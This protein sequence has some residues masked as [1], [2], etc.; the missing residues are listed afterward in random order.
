MRIGLVVP[1][2]IHPSGTTDVIPALI[3]LI[4]RLARRH[5]VTAIVLG[6]SFLPK[7]FVLHG[8]EVIDL[9]RARMLAPD[10]P[11]A[12]ASLI[13]ILAPRKVELIHAFWAG[14]PGFAAG[15]AA[16][17]LRTPMLLSIAGGEL[18]R[19][20]DIRYG[21]QRSPLER[22]LVR[23][24]LSLADLTTAG[25]RALI[26]HLPSSFGARWLPLGADRALFDHLPSYE[27]KDRFR[28][29]HVAS[30]NR[31]KDPHLLLDAFERI[32]SSGVD[33][34]LDW[35][36]VDTLGGEVQRRARRLGL[37]DRVRFL[38]FVPQRQ[39]AAYYRSADLYIHTSRFESQSVAVLEAALSGLPIVSTRVGLVAELAPEG[40]IAV[41][42][43][44]PAALADAVLALLGDPQRRRALGQAARAFAIA[45]DADWTASELER[46]YEALLATRR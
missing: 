38:G 32:V 16:R 15:L 43:G 37:D 39:L 35:A 21:A 12:V 5:S 46:I 26:E 33:V 45:H 2:G 28:L 23:W 40:A 7:R 29:L 6:Q 22:R 27:A 44:D 3:A 11:A 19:F 4:E 31:V 1:G 14:H 13:A 41:D 34:R 24:S 18:V 10:L 36:G 9:G 8:A 30:I 20:D 25:S 17:V 42:V